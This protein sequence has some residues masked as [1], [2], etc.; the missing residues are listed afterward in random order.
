[1]GSFRLLTEIRFRNL[2]SF[3]QYWQLENS[4]RLLT[5]IRFRNSKRKSSGLDKRRNVSVSL[6]RFD[7]EISLE[8]ETGDQN[9]KKVSVSLRRFDFEISSRRHG[10]QLA[11][12]GVSV[13]LRRFDFEI[14]PEWNHQHYWQLPVSVSLRRFD[15]E[16]LPLIYAKENAVW[17]FRL[18]TEIR[19]RNY[20]KFLTIF[21]SDRFPSPYGDS[22]SKWFAVKWDCYKQRI[23]SV[24]LRRFDFEITSCAVWRTIGCWLLAF[25]SPYGDSIS[26]CLSSLS[27]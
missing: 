25:P 14:R 4:F 24:S 12:K 10:N 11:R 5:E 26:K 6:R 9:Y 13:S 1:M 19:F 7:F 15:F 22:I 2:L 21:N 16:I 8:K 17:S 23:V 20:R 18:L 3:L 27:I